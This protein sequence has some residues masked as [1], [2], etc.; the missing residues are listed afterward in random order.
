LAVN[1]L[2]PESLAI[3]EAEVLDHQEVAVEHFVLTLRAPEIADAARPGQ[4]VMVRSLGAWDPLLPRA[5]SVYHADAERGAIQILYRE[6]GRGTGALRRN[7]A[8]GRVHAWGPLGNQFRAPEGRRAVLVGGGVGVPPLVYWAEHLRALDTGIHV[9]ALIGAGS[10][11]Y[12]V[13]QERLREAGAALHTA[14]DDGSAGHHGYVTELLPPLLEDSRATVYACGPMGMLAAV[15]RIAE[16]RGVPTELALE[17]PMACGVGAC[18][19]CTVP[20]R[21]GGYYRVCTDGPV[22]SGE[23]IA[24]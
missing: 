16:A 3:L 12:L 19:G 8:G 1:Y 21:D 6:V 23:S 5:Y 9:T 22:F 13:G 11:K 18:I 2:M 20:K 14:T 15:S 4:F 24:W 17:A 10:A 7:P